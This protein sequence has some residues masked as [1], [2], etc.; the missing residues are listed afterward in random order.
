VAASQNHFVRSNSTGESLVRCC[1]FKDEASCGGFK[2]PLSTDLANTTFKEWRALST[3]SISD[4]IWV[5][6][7][8]EITL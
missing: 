4:C 5:V 2:E 8:V 3:K 7:A 6:D 1:S